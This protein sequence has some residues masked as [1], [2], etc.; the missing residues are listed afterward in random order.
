M[1]SLGRSIVPSDQPFLDQ[2]NWRFQKGGS[3]VR[4]LLKAVVR[5]DTFRFRRGEPADPRAAM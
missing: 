5:S 2:I 1:F 4:A 3:N